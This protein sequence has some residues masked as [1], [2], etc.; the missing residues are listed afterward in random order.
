MNKNLISKYFL[1]SNENLVSLGLL[2]LRCIIGVI[3]FMVGAGKV[4]GWFGG[5]GL[6]TTLQFYTKMGI[7]T[8][9][10]YLSCFTEF[11]GGFLLIV[12][13]F[14]RP[15]AIAVIVN[16]IVATIVMLPKGF[17]FGM[18]DFPFTFLVIAVVI[19]ITGPKNFSL[20]FYFFK[21]DLN[22]E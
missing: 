20:D 14:T 8:P 6:S 7:S 17:I 16:M 11:I 5:F 3:L 13:L 2:F 9:L 15:A 1:S 18:A 21:I 4:L 10:A 19:L 22:I 12:G